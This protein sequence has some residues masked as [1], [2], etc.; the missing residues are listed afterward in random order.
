[1]L[2]KNNKKIKNEH[3]EHNVFFAK[4]EVPSGFEPL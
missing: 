3:I 1:M 2:R 4:F